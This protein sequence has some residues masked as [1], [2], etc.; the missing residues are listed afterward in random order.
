MALAKN[1]TQRVFCIPCVGSPE[2]FKMAWTQDVLLPLLKVAMV[3]GA[4]FSLLTM[5]SV[6]EPEHTPGILK[7]PLVFVRARM[8]LG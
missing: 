8:M 5:R 1:I 7:S 4:N 2:D 6:L 3:R